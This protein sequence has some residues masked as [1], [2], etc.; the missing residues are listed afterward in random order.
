M[1][2][3]DYLAGRKILEK[4][5]SKVNGEITVVKELLWGVSIFAGGLPQSGGLAKKI[6]MKPLVEVKKI[7]K[8]NPPK[9]VLIL[10]FAGGGMSHMVRK[11]WPKAEIIGIDIDPIM[12][13][14][15]KK[16]LNWEESGAKVRIKDAISFI[17]ETKKNGNK[18]DLICVDMYVG[19]SV[20][21]QF[22]TLKFVKSV[23]AIMS[24]EGISVFN[25]LYG[26]NNR[27][28]A[29]KFKKILQN[30]F[31]KVRAVRPEANIMFICSNIV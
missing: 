20:P 6:W 21:E 3:I 4:E 9:N 23:K 15:G 19:A 22:N 17:E 25:R 8:S 30:V 26:K 12:V 27:E 1:S 24:N 29:D 31:S 11:H 10:G 16:Y 2:A 5:N 28:I 7:T 13:K 18:Y 14:F